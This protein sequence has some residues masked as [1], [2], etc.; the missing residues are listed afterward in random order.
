M[1]KVAEL[2][3]VYEVDEQ[4]ATILF[5]EIPDGRVME[6]VFGITGQRCVRGGVPV[7]FINL[8]GCSAGQVRSLLTAD[9]I[10]GI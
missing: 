1:R 4:E 8:N 10:H 9:E 2:S 7:C 6:G 3:Q 5:G